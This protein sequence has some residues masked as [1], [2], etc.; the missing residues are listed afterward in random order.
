MTSEN[1]LFNVVVESF[2]SDFGFSSPESWTSQSFTIEPLRIQ[3][4]LPP[5]SEQKDSTT[6]S[7]LTFPD[8]GQG[9]SVFSPFFHHCDR[10]NLC[11]QIKI[12]KAHYHTCF[13]GHYSGSPSL[14]TSD[15]ISMSALTRSIISLIDRCQISKIIGFGIGL[16]ATVLLRAAAQI[17]TK[18]SGLVLI[19]PIIYPSSYAER[20]S[21]ST[22]GL[23]SRQLGLGLTRRTKDRL[24]ARWLSY[25]T[26]EE[27]SGPA[28]ALEEELDRRNP[29]NV[30]LALAED[31]WREDAS[32]II[33]QAKTRILLVTGKASALRYH[34]EDAI[35]KFD[36]ENVSRIDV[37]G[38]GSLVHDED[39]DRIARAVSLF[40]QGIPGFC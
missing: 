6:P 32:E 23:F 37:V 15:D 10:S 33:K 38:A 11:P 26:N 24:L 20:F 30:Q 34:V 39:P 40:L 7:I 22:D 25:Q 9:E 28:Q 4:H 8:I 2:D 1:S 14:S 35:E 5:D 19:S 36:A 3:E 27:S 16:G 13:P 31:T 17:P 21:Q 29:Y 18:F 12:A